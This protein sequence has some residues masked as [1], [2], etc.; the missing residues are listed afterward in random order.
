[1]RAVNQALTKI[2]NKNL[3]LKQIIMK[4]VSRI[5][6]SGMTGLTKL[7]V[8]NIVNEL[9]GDGYITEGEQEIHSVPGRRPIVLKPDTTKHYILGIYLCRDSVSAFSANLCGEIIHME[10]IPF[11]DETAESVGQKI[12]RAADKIIKLEKNIIGI[13][14]SSIGP[15]GIKDGVLREPPHF[16]G[17]EY[18]DIRGLLENAFALPVFT[19]N[20]MNT[21]ALAEKYWGKGADLDNFIYLGAAKGI[22]AGII[23]KGRL[24]EG[25][26]GE[27]GHVSVDING[28]QCPCGNKGCLEMYASISSNANKNNKQD[29]CRYLAEGCITLINLFNPDKI[30]LGHRIPHLGCDAADIIAKNI[31]NRY[32]GSKYKHVGIEFSQF[33][34]KAP[35]Y[36]AAAIFIDKYKF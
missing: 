25:D 14:V 11:D 12:I 21:S 4:P 6:L 18:I 29:I 23:L 3:I 2:N 19:D 22:G 5:E 36:G 34:D 27:I 28:K 7:T 26:F 24:C 32:I 33:Y 1:M 13:G 31:G 8:S 10:S 15:V 17:I 9:I 16:F 35:L 30:F 20:D